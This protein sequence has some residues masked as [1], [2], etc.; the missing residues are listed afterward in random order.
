YRRIEPG[1]Q[2][3]LDCND[4]IN[5]R[6]ALCLGY[7]IVL[8]RMLEREGYR[9]N[10]ISMVALGH[11]RGRGPKQEDSHEVLEVKIDGRAMILDPMANTCHPFS[12]EELMRDPSLAVSKLAPDGR[13]RQRHYELYDTAE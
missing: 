8:G 9:V 5:G 10:W 4:L 11:A 3:S 2:P 13:Y 7:C 1:L 12:L 6:S